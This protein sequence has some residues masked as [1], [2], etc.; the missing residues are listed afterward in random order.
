[1]FVLVTPLG[2]LSVLVS[3]ILAS[4]F[5]R[6]DLNIHGKIGCFL[7]LVGSVV[8][9][10][11]APQE[12]SIATVEELSAKLTDAAFVAYACIV[13]LVSVVLIFHYGPRYG[14]ENILIY[15][16]ICSLVGSLSV[17]GCKGLG[18][19]LKQ[20]FNGENE[21]KNPVAWM[22]L[23][24]VA[25]CIVTQMNY[26]NKALDIFNTALVTPIYYVMFT[27]LTIIASAILFKE[28]SN[29]NAK[30][31]LGALAGLLT[32]IVGVFLLHAFRD[33]KFSIHDLPGLS[34]FARSSS[35]RPRTD[36]AEQV[37][38]QNIVEGDSDEDS[39]VE[40]KVVGNS[41]GNHS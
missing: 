3:A 20:L 31:V 23:F 33:V 30:D 21:L 26:L 35:T 9:V 39:E 27:T 38:M 2:A 19:V 11:H 14:K 13:L 29:R 36:G 24:A 40:V 4:Y 41:V 5:L 15:V 25:G 7:S 34:K 12:E 1:V 6:E 16:A 22:L 37:L 8:L 17:M 18:I 10:I 28:W 32:I